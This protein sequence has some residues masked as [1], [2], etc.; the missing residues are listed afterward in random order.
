MNGKPTPGPYAIA[1]GKYGKATI[2]TA[3]V[4]ET[5]AINGRKILAT[6]ERDADA[7]LFGA[8]PDLLKALQRLIVA[9]LAS[10]DEFKEKEIIELEAALT[11][12][13]A[14]IAKAQ[15]S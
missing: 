15:P 1:V 7:P 10:R 14:A 9:E 4:P 5:Q 12:A 8:A 13:K 11:E 6:V 3:D 2:T